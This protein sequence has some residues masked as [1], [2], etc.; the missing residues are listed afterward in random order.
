ME[1]NRWTKHHP[2]ICTQKRINHRIIIASFVIFRAVILIVSFLDIAI[3]ILDTLPPICYNYFDVAT[4]SFGIVIYSIPITTTTAL[5][6]WLFWR[7]YLGVKISFGIDIF[8]NRTSSL[9]RLNHAIRTAQQQ[10][11]SAIQHFDECVSKSVYFKFDGSYW[12]ATH[13]DLSMDDSCIELRS[14]STLSKLT[15]GLVR[16]VKVE[17]VARARWKSVGSAA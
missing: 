10:R 4:T 3:S 2:R 1:R 5:H 11:R 15:C 9:A 17:Y 13:S 8:R 14:N 6:F 7:C 16:M 12:T